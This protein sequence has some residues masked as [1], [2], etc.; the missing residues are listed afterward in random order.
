MYCHRGS[1]LCPFLGIVS[2]LLLGG[3]TCLAGDDSWKERFLA[4]APR[5]WAEYVSRSER[6]Q[7]SATFS[8][9]D[10]LAGEK[11]TEKGGSQFKQIRDR[12]CALV[13]WMLEDG[14]GKRQTLHG[15]NS[16]YQFELARADAESPWVLVRWKPNASGEG[17]TKALAL[18][19]VDQ[20]THAALQFIFPEDQLPRLIKQAE[21]TVQA[22]TPMTFGGRELAKVEFAYRPKKFDKPQPR[23]TGGWVLLDP[24]RYWVI[25]KYEISALWVSG[26]YSGNSSWTGIYEYEESVDGLPMLKRVV[27]RQKEVDHNGK[28]QDFELR[29][30]FKIVEGDVPESEFFCPP[31]ACPSRSRRIRKRNRSGQIPI[32]PR[33]IHKNRC[34][35]TFGS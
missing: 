14:W 17:D 4:E 29:Q 27:R 24:E 5:K 30:E 13:V 9:N 7:G 35:R 28:A 16:Q 20:A 31:S 6:F 34:R 26:A 15:V 21:F 12:D 18:T 1:L 19:G 11:W 32:P 10:M 33:S 23:P 22:V 8:N 3:Q 25:Q 2:L